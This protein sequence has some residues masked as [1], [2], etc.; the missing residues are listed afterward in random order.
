MAELSKL[1]LSECLD[2]L[3]SDRPSLG[4][5]AAAAIALAL[6]AGCAAKAAG[7][8]AKHDAAQTMHAAQ[9]ELEALGRRAL[10]AGQQESQR[11]VRFVRDSRTENLKPLVATENELEQ[12]CGKVLERITALQDEVD[13]SVSGDLLAARAL[14][15]AFLTIEKHNRAENSDRIP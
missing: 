15:E 8:S 12:I 4:S 2:M 9:R 14:C 1:R 5:G 13:A 11:F 6:A 3:A 10:A 7:V